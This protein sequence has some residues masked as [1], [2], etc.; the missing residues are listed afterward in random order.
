LL[1]L[2]KAIAAETASL[3]LLSR[4]AAFLKRA[5]HDPELRFETL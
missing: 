3:D 4:I 5:Q 2:Q 1:L